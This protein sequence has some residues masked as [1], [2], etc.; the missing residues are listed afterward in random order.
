MH[1]MQKKLLNN[2][3]SGNTFPFHVTTNQKRKLKFHL[4]KV[5]ISS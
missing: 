5:L 4:K 2:T 3:R 1:Q